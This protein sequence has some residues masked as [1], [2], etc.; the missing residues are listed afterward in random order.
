MQSLLQTEHTARGAAE[1]QGWA[2]Q[3]PVDQQTG[4]GR[5]RPATSP[6]D[7]T[8]IKQCNGFVIYPLLVRTAELR[9]GGQGVRGDGGGAQAVRGLQIREMCGVSDYLPPVHCTPQT[10]GHHIQT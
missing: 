8:L 1:L 10:L 9:A 6:A 7:S 3:R 4:L 2:Q 5:G